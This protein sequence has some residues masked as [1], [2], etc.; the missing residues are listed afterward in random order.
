MNFCQHTRLLTKSVNFKALLMY[1]VREFMS[2]NI[3]RKV[4]VTYLLPIIDYADIMYTNT[5]VDLDLLAELQNCQNRCLK[6]CFKS[7]MLTPTENVHRK[8]Q[9]PTLEMRRRYHVDLYAFKRAQQPYFLIHPGRNTRLNQGPILYYPI[10]HC[11][12]FE[13]SP[14]VVCAQR[15]NSLDIDMRN[16]VNLD[17]FKSKARNTLDATI[18][19]KY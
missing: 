13:K 14:L 10:I 16:S 11:T 2:E 15:W 3:L 9:L 18:P 8:A 6:T 17:A 1:M 19:V 4:Y 5:N 12:A 7:H